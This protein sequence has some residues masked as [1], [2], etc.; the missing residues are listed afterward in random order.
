MQHQQR[1]R[2]RGM[3]LVNKSCEEGEN[4]RTG[5]L[6]GDELVLLLS[7]AEDEERVRGTG[8]NGPVV[9]LHGGHG[10]GGAGG[11]AGS[12]RHES[13][14][15]VLGELRAFRADETSQ[16]WRCP[17]ALAR[18]INVLLRILTRRPDLM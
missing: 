7:P 18:Y 12:P 15:C 14:A 5:P 11:D 1:Q 4:E 9:Q 8:E 16:C 6:G 17:R 3:D 13:L 2:M 10:G